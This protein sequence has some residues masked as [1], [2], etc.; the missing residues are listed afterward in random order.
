MHIGIVYVADKREARD[1]TFKVVEW[2]RGKGHEISVYCEDLF[3]VEDNSVLKKLEAVITFGGD[4]LVLHVA[5]QIA[6]LGI[7]LL[8]VNF[9]EVGFLT[10]IEPQEIYEKLEM[11]L[12]GKCKATE[13]GRIQ[14]IVKNCRGCGIYKIDAL[15]EIVIGGISRT[16][17]LR[18]MV[19]GKKPF[20]VTIKS[21]G[22]IFS[23]ETGSTA[24][25]LNAGGP[26]IHGGE[27]FTT[28]ATANNGLFK[29][30]SPS[31]NSKLVNV[32]SF[33]II[34][35]FAITVEN[36][37]RYEQNIPFVIAD[38]QKDY[39]LEKG[40]M[41]VIKKSPQSTIFFEFE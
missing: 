1:I 38:S 34:G 36:I 11:F 31:P 17:A 4:G 18:M 21:D 9:G 39:R 10:N 13:R 14:V 7:G 33:V 27:I 24:Y 15:N 2:L 3:L 5:N 32:K 40:D 12:A 35:E 28:T 19:S 26:V 25:N 20:E 23:T 37:S 6:P 22:A 29:Y 8:R 41:V 30:K 16:V